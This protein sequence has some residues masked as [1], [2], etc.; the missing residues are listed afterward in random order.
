MKNYRT[1]AIIGSTGSIGKTVL[2]VINK[3]K[4]KFKIILLTANENYKELLKQTKKFEV[5]NVIITNKIAFEKFKKLN[6]D[7]NINIFNDFKNINKIFKNKIDYVMSSI[8][9]LKGLEPTL[10]TIKYTK[11]IAIA[12]KESIICGWNL[13][14]KQIKKYK[15]KLIPVDSE[16]FSIWY[17]TN[18]DNIDK[19]ILTASGGPLLNMSKKKIE[20]VKLKDVLN[21]PNWKMGSKITVDSSTLMNKV[22]EVIE[23][24]NIFNL[25]L[26][27][28]SV[29]I[30]PNSYVHAI[31][32]FNSG[33][34]KIIAHDTTMEIP[35]FNS[36]YLDKKKYSFKNDININ[37]INNLNLKKVD[38]FKFPLIKILNLI[39]DKISL[40][41]TLVVSANDEL[42]K[43]YLKGIIKY[44]QIPLKLLNFVKNKKFSKFKKKVPKNISEIINL[45]NYVR[46]KLNSKV[47]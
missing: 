8:V 18:S 9:G 24:R 30:H 46:L 33:M 13:I 12:N 25:K 35:I 17:S 5:S 15:T 6:K 22:F 10:E 21:H 27:N 19:V 44:N 37:I 23:A 34:I 45:D 36:I 42:V 40:Y 20:N 47:V 2:K 1:I 7:L 4:D 3:N 16:H 26:K 28:I 41:E 32:R 14:E 43:M 38:T 11:T 39:P 31:I 29:L